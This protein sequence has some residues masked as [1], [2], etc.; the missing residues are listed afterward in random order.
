MLD[1]APEM[2]KNLHIRASIAANIFPGVI[3]LDPAKSREKGR[4]ER[5]EGQGEGKDRE[6]GHWR[7]KSRR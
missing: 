7:R 4:T 2:H 6:K 5:W 1:F 3:S